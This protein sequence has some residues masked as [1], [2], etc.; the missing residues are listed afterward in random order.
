MNFKNFTIKA[1]ESVQEA[2]EQVKNKNQQVIVP[3]H[4]NDKSRR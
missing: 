3:A 4:V 2:I 1:Q